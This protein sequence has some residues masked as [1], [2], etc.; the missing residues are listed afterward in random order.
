MCTIISLFMIL[1]TKRFS[2]FFLSFLSFFLSLTFVFFRI[3]PESGF[4]QGVGVNSGSLSCQHGVKVRQQNINT[5]KT[6]ETSN[7]LNKLVFFFRDFVRVLK[8]FT[9]STPKFGLVCLS[10]HQQTHP[11]ILNPLSLSG[12]TFNMSKVNRNASGQQK[13]PIIYSSLARFDLDSLIWKPVLGNI[14]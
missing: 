14:S 12:G 6:I 7:L 3:L 10:T 1:R 2:S 11:P 5:N 4:D 13:G 8:L 9:S